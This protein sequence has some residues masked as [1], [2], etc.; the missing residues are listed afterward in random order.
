MV[1][2]CPFL[3]KPCIEADCQL[4]VEATAHPEIGGE[5]LDIP[6]YHLAE[7]AIKITAT[8]ACMQMSEETIRTY[9]V[10]A[11]IGLEDQG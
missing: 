4:W 3:N 5:K 9:L 6:P 11:G 7:C 2:L 10:K 1:K 8:H